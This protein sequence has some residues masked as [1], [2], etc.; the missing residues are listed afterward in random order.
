MISLTSGSSL[1][2]D[3]EVA[4]NNEWSYRMQNLIIENAM[5]ANER[6]VMN[7][8]MTELLDRLHRTEDGKNI[9]YVVSRHTGI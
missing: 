4:N 6:N 7:R 5:L 2:V 3:L 9:D 1:P 8:E